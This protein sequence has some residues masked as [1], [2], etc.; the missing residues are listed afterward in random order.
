MEGRITKNIQ[1][2]DLRAKVDFIYTRIKTQDIPLTWVKIWNILSLKGKKC[3]AQHHQHSENFTTTKEHMLRTLEEFNVYNV[4]DNLLDCIDE[5]CT[6][7]INL[8][9]LNNIYNLL[10]SII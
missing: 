5:N 9:E 4:I 8:Y 7:E 2:P 3:K 10:L 6:N 1:N